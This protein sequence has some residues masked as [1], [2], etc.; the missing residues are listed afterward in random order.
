MDQP[1]FAGGK[2]ALIGGGRM[3]QALLAG[4]IRDG[5]LAADQVHVIEPSPGTQGWWRQ[6]QPGCRVDTEIIEAVH[7]AQT[8]IL[9]VK[10][11]LLPLVAG[12]AA[13]H[14]GGRPILSV[15]AGVPLA[16]LIEWFGTDRVIRVMPNTPALVGA[17][18][19]AYCCGGGASE[20]DKQ[21]VHAILSAVGWAVEV[22]EK[23]MDAVT[24]LSG[25][26]PAYVCLVIEALADG[27]VLAGLPR[28]TAMKLATQTVL[29]T[30][31]M[32]GQTGQH[33][34]QLKDAVA[35]PGGTTIAALASLEQNGLRASL[36]NAVHAAAV[37]SRELG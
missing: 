35:S 24:G 9:A 30:A 7:D 32:V 10:P 6:Q 19:S 11:D 28:D 16:K 14:W 37:R 17:G 8:V 12:Q 23:Q 3:G 22:A 20:A 31:Q 2:T 15:A 5:R 18:A 4:L 27:G 34:A 1:T 33:P 25:S 13:G 21:Q 26:G 29:G 36:I